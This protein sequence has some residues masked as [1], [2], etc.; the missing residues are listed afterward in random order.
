MAWFYKQ[1]SA[2]VL[3]AII[4]GAAGLSLTW[5]YLVPIYQSPDEPVHLDY[6]LCLLEHR[7]LFRASDVSAIR[8]NRDYD[9]YLLH[10]YTQ[11]LLDRCECATVTYN[12]QAKVPPGYGTEAFFENL[13]RDKPSRDSITIDRPPSL[14]TWYP[15]GYYALLALWLKGVHFFSGS[16][17]TI[18][19][20]ARIF[21]VALLVVNLLFGYGILRELS[22]PKAT[23]L[24]LITCIAFFPL[25]SFVSSYVQP[26]NLSGVL[27]TSCLYF[28]LRARRDPNSTLCTGLLGLSLAV[29]LVTKP[30][31]FL[32]VL[33]PVLGTVIVSRIAGSRKRLN[34]LRWAVL[35][36]GP[37]LLL[38]SIQVWTTWGLNQSPLP[39]GVYENYLWQVPAALRKALGDFYWGTTHRSFWGIFGWLDA[40]LVFGNELVTKV[41]FGLI[42]IVSL[43]FVGLTLVRFVQV[44]TRLARIF[45]SGR[46]LVALRILVSNPALNSYFLFTAFMV[47]LFV[48]T[49]NIFGAQ[50]RHWFPFLLPIFIASVLYAPK[51]LKRR[52]A[53][54]ALVSLSLLG[55]CTYS[56]VG[57][58][59][60][61]ETLRQR[62][63]PDGFDRPLHEASISV[64][65]TI[66]HEA[67]EGGATDSALVFAL[68]K[69]RFVRCLRL[70]Y[71]LSHAAPDR[72]RFHASW[73]NSSKKGLRKEQGVVYQIRTPSGERWM[74]IWVN[75]IIDGFRLEPDN[76]SCWFEVKKL[77]VVTDVT[78]ER[79]TSD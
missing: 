29:L 38:G 39:A 70:R 41:L 66:K 56:L 52:S 24:L 72:A 9:F 36:A 55:L 47:T 3:G 50:G 1:W 73:W 44:A 28:G 54:T 23:A 69:P 40:P 30:H 62:Y 6:A 76:K 17:C 25:T 74:S 43:V 63:Y 19:F 2:L 75:G 26:D 71:Q 14:V 20:G 49:D 78:D 58:C 45:R 21:S 4:A 46:R 57:S 67:T 12:D 42:H 8:T 65:K 48:C 22:L 33:V 11:Y 10:P 32:C 79:S 53:R 15:F 34:W 59:F 77:V 68:D 37:M 27:V 64:A 61:V 31:H 16:I 5:V 13:D 60:A 35:F 18:Y 51:A 7:A